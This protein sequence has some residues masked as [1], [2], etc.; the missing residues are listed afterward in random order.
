VA[1]VSDRVRGLL[2]AKGR[3]QNELEGID[4]NE[5]GQW[6]GGFKK[7]DPSDLKRLAEA[8]DSTSDY[9][10]GLGKEAEF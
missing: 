9:L 6:L 1:L 10:I 4:S 2:K 3:Q 8:L 5:L 7:M